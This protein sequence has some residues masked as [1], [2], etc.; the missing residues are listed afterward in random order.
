MNRTITKSVLSI[1]IAAFAILSAVQARAQVPY[2]FAYSS[3]R[4]G[5]LSVPSI[6]R[7]YTPTSAVV[8]YD[9]SHSPDLGNTNILALVKP[10]AHIA[11]WNLAT[12]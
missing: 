2:I 9:G 11:T 3:Y 10:M 6:V 8:Y 7:T 4:T 12:R 5:A 1:L